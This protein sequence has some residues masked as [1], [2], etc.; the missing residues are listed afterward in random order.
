MQSTHMLI[1]SQSPMTHPDTERPRRW[2]VI[3]V[4]CFISCMLILWLL[5]DTS[6]HDI[7][8]VL[9]SSCLPLM[10][11]AFSL[12]FLGCFIS[13]LRW[14][15]LLLCQ[16][17]DI[18]LSFLLKSYMAAIFFNNLLP[19]TIGGDV[20]RI[21]DT[22]RAGKNKA[23]AVTAVLVDRLL[24]ILVLMGFVFFS[25]LS[26]ERFNIYFSFVNKLIA[27]V[28]VVFTISFIIFILYMYNK[29][30]SQFY[31]KTN[32][33]VIKTITD[34]IKKAIDLLIVF[35]NDKKTLYISVLL[36]IALQINVVLYYFLISNSSGIS[37]S[38]NEFFFIVP[39]AVFFMMMPISINGLG[40][41]E[42]IFVF[43]LS[44]YGVS[45]NNAI[46]FSWADYGMILSLGIIGGIVYILRK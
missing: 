27:L 33:T 25:L 43:M 12:H 35:K 13:V 9:Q 45:K 29:K 44:T 21:H 36:S 39:V 7:F 15:V 26:S 34:I 6:L 28:V 17:I 22:Y 24:G 30:I 2:M 14:R 42:N 8:K 3:I 32:N 18:S 40:L 19:S 31:L 46:A 4:K 11:L 16:N 10:L 20:L 5:K 37:I 41:R 38:I 1:G 23:G